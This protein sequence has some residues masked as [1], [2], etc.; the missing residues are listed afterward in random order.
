MAVTPIR[1]IWQSYYHP[2]QTPISKSFWIVQQ[3][4]RILLS[5]FESES[6]LD[7]LQQ[8]FNIY[9]RIGLDTVT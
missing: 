1:I 7:V 9:T 4:P 5:P 2:S 3:L 8:R 6:G